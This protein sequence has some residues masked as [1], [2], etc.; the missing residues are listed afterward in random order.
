[1]L[2]CLYVHSVPLIWSSD[3]GPFR[4]HD[5]FLGGP[6][7]NRLS[8]NKRFRIYGLNFG[9]GQWSLSASKGAR[10]ASLMSLHYLQVNVTSSQVSTDQIKAV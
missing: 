10:A 8:Y 7:R 4:P 1:M 3:I 9:Y 2:T 5:Q 6:E